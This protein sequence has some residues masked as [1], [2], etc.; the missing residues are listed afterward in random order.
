MEVFEDD[1]LRFMDEKGIAAAHL[2]GY[3]M[4]GFVALRLALRAP[5][6]IL[7]LGTLATKMDWTEASCAAESSMLQPEAIAE[8]V[9]R[10]AEMLAATHPRNGWRKVVSE[11]QRMIAEMHLHR[12]TEEALSHIQQPA[13]IMLGDR[14]KM[15]SIEETVAL[16]RALPDASLAVMPDTPHP[17]ERANMQVLAALIGQAVQ[18]P[19]AQKR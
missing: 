15:V 11:T 18:R 10:F 12:I 3:S 19:A 8:K 6:R 4:G 14:D 7:S 2:F 9:P 13:C 16:Y 5:E 1:V 17:L